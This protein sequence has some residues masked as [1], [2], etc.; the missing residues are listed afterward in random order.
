[1]TDKTEQQP[2]PIPV[3]IRVYPEPPRDRKPREHV[4]AIRPDTMIVFDTETTTDPTQRLLFGCYRF[5]ENGISVEEGL[6][7]APD[8]STYQV[9]TLREYAARN[10]SSHQ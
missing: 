6:F 1:M 3:A 7:H 2:Y 4:K 5:I 9:K 10:H 8:L